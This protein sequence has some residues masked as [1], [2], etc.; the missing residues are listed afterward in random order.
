MKP[1]GANHFTSLTAKKGRHGV[2]KAAPLIR[3][4]VKGRG[5]LEKTEESESVSGVSALV[6]VDGNSGDPLAAVLINGG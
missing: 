3:W 4:L 5:D 1:H 2:L 6:L